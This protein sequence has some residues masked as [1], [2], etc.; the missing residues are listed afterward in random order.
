M[1]PVPSEWVR[2]WS[3][4]AHAGQPRGVRSGQPLCLLPSAPLCTGG[5]PRALWGRQRA[6]PQGLPSW[7]LWS[8]PSPSWLGA[9]GCSACPGEPRLGSPAPSRCQVP[10]FLPFLERGGWSPHPGGGGEGAGSGGVRC[11][12]QQRRQKQGS[13]LKV[14]AAICQ[15]AALP[16]LPQPRGAR[17][18]PGD[19]NPRSP[20]VQVGMPRGGGA[21]CPGWRGLQ[22][23]VLP[24][25]TDQPLS[26]EWAVCV[27]VG[28]WWTVWV[29]LVCSVGPLKVERL[30]CT[31][32]GK[33]L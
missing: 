7:G 24:I 14:A 32:V 6:G 11:S 18:A 23:S 25:P 16:G 22:G 21:G 4:R 29:G 3:E 17:S 13:A 19:Q 2:S 30:P 20:R 10:V 8:L 27:S 26:H 15:G 33:Y 12:A 1:R 9:G 5:T 28:G 31:C